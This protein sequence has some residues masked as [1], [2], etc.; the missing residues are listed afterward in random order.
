MS[1]H[2]PACLCPRCNFDIWKEEFSKPSFLAKKILP[3][4]KAAK[5]AYA[6]DGITYDGMGFAMTLTPPPKPV[7]EKCND[8]G[9]VKDSTGLYPSPCDLCAETGEGNQTWAKV[10]DGRDAEK[11]PK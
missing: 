1:A 8:T 6:K 10:K 9:S 4:F 5:E 2:G 3:G 7:C 11:M